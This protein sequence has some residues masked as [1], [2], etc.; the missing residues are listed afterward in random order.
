MEKEAA[1]R[2]LGC[3]P[4]VRVSFLL[5]NGKPT[6][7]RGGRR[8]PCDIIYTTLIECKKDKDV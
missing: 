7:F 4:Y 8:S 5:G 3:N 6:S 2:I 1:V